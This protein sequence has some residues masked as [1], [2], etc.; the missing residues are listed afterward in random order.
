MASQALN[1]AKKDKFD[2]FYTKLSDIEKELSHYKEHFKG[3]II[4]CNCDDPKIS[5]FYAYFIKNYKALKLK[6][7]LK[8]LSLVIN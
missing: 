8:T 3:K 5:N 4:L 1:L 2:E 7:I 6:N